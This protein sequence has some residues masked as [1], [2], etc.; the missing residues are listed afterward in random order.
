[1]IFQIIKRFDIELILKLVNKKES[2]QEVKAI[3][4][5]IKNRLYFIL[6]PVRKRAHYVVERSRFLI[7]EFGFWIEML[8][9]DAQLFCRSLNPKSEI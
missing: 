7:L 6:L 5:V 1:M 9:V 4:I 2:L 3:K 8:Q